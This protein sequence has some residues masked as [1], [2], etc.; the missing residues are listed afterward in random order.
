MEKNLCR[1]RA[2][3]ISFLLLLIGLPSHARQNVS[4][5]Y[6]PTIYGIVLNSSGWPSNNPLYGVYSFMPDKS[7]IVTSPEHL[8]NWMRA[9]SGGVWFNRRLH[10]MNSL[11]GSGN[12]VLNEYQCW[13]TDTWELETR[14]NRCLVFSLPMTARPTSWARCSSAP[15]R[16]P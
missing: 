7:V 14:P 6:V 16:H 4:A 11:Q 9:N 5:S 12:N 8:D 15:M 2:F 1:L 13:N 3:L 10:Y